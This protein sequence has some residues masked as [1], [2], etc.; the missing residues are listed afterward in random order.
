MAAEVQIL[1]SMSCR[2][3]RG[4][5]EHCHSSSSACHKDSAVD[6]RVRLFNT[7]RA[8]SNSSRSMNLLPP[9]SYLSCVGPV[10]VE[11]LQ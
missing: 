6:S 8:G 10:Q 2:G 9:L 3:L 4:T 5:V 1:M 7:G 11:A